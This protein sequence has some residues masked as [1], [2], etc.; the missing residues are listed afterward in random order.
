M[1][2]LLAFPEWDNRWIP[3]FKKT[4]SCHDVSTIR[5]DELSL[6][7]LWEQ[8]IKADVLINMWADQVTQFWA[9]HMKD[10][11]IISYLRRYELYAENWL[12]A[13]AWKDV[14]ALIFVSEHIRE[15]FHR[16]QRNGTPQRIY[17]FYNAVDPEQFPFEEHDRKPTKI[18]FVC[19]MRVHKNFGL[20]AQILQALPEE[21]TLH[22]IG[23]INSNDKQVWTECFQNLG[24]AD[25]W[26]WNAKVTANRIPRWLKDKDFILSASFTEGNPNNMIEGMAT[27]CIPVVHN[28]PGAKDQFHNDYVFNTVAEAVKIITR[29]RCDERRFQRLWVE[30]NY[31]MSNIRRIHEVIKDIS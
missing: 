31:S 3:Y 30:T 5:T 17:C 23:G 9:H 4:L 14:D 11:K 6:N 1:K 15:L 21:Y 22:H 27:G 18:A 10:K 16:S 24:I 12:Q 20:A 19:S 28:W 29:R 25:R 2:V 26:E 7:K 8:S 13:T